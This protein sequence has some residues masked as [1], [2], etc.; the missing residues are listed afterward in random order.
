MN[1]LHVNHAGFRRA[2]AEEADPHRLSSG[3]APRQGRAATPTS[4]V[5]NSRRFY[6]TELHLTLDEVD[7]VRLPDRLIAERSCQ[8]SLAGSFTSFLPSRR[9]R[10]AP[11]ADIRPMPAFMSTRLAAP[12]RL[13]RPRAVGFSAVNS[14]T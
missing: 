9:V 2:A 6:L 1:P 14:P 12:G 10:F 4:S 13:A 5:T 7:Q 3:R 8:M 11:R